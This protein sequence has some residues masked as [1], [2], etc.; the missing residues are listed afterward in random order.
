M[1]GA[2]VDY[3]ST[4]NRCRAVIFYFV[5]LSSCVAE[6]REIFV[7]KY[8]AD[9]S[10]GDAES[11]FLTIQRAADVAHPGDTITVRAG[12]YRERID[13]PRGGASEAQRIVYRAEP[14]ADVRIVGSERAADW[15]RDGDHWSAVLPRSFFGSLNPFATLVRHPKFVKGDND[16]GWGWL[17]Y[18][19]WAHLG[20]VYINGEGLTEQETDAGLASPLTWRATVDEEGATT[21]TANFGDKDPNAECVEV[22]VRPTAFYPSK[23]GL[24]FITLQGFT[25][26]HVA[27]HW[28][29]PIE[30]QVA[31]V[32]PNGGHHWIIEDNTI[33]YAKGVGISL[34]VPSGPADHESSGHHIV[35]SNMIM[36]CGQAG[37]VGHGWSSRSTI[38]RNS[39]EE[40]N[41]RR[42]FGGAETGGIKFHH[43][44]DT[45][46]ENN[47]IRK[48]CTLDPQT[49]NGDGIW[50]DA[51]NYENVVRNNVILEVEGNAILM[52][53]NWVGAN[54]IEN[55]V[56]IG[57][58]LATYSACDTVWRYNL[59]VDAP[60]VWVNQDDLGR[61]PVGGA[62]WYKNIFIRRGVA[63][64]P[65]STHENL[66]LGGA[67]PRDDEPNAVV[68]L[69]DP[70]FMIDLDDEQV[71]VS[72]DI[73]PASFHELRGKAGEG[74]DFYGNQRGSDDFVYGPFANVVPGRNVMHVFR[75]SDRHAL[76][77]K[78]LLRATD[79]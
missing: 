28:A 10:S 36:R 58:R 27:C 29:P 43:A 44:H 71:T 16:D 79:E 31:A 19:R 32:G 60:G 7:A 75:Y 8:G 1:I 22:N 50:L 65:D 68:M 37:I 52:E 45:I 6:S 2:L 9:T 63:E 17:R 3:S 67:Q 76:V 15:E 35:R 40:I 25:I 73:D 74:I 23:P 48:I 64:G 14:G 11:P 69:A 61:P 21:I 41:Y 12:V 24:S 18:G 49:S 46:I 70:H 55:N 57:S 47:L 5:A 34:G 66:Y 42:E 54:Y 20:D 56:V 78:V 51:G 13:P 39:I 26:M 62:V 53:A 59:F 77:R 38:S 33:L 4:M 72:F 30:E